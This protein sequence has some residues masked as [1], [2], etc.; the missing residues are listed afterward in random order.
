MTSRPPRGKRPAKIVRLES[1]RVD[2]FDRASRV[3]VEVQSDLHH[4]S[5]SD[6]ASDT[7][8]RNALIDAGWQ[9]VEVTEYEVWHQPD[10][11]CRRLRTVRDGKPTRTGR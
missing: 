10:V 2:F 3:I 6:R 11:V 7:E 1:G 8:R 5:V 4:T 9:F